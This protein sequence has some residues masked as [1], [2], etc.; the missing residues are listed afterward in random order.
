M[1]HYSDITNGFIQGFGISTQEVKAL[2]TRK[3][4]WTGIFSIMNHIAVI[5]AF[6][7]MAKRINFFTASKMAKTAAFFFASSLIIFYLGLN[8][9]KVYAFKTYGAKKHGHNHSSHNTKS[10]DSV[11][12]KTILT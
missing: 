10:L 5:W 11:D 9:Y 2:A 7:I 8:V 12:K 1:H 3:E 4:S 6:I